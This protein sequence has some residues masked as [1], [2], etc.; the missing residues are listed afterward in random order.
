MTIEE[1]ADVLGVE[2]KIHYSPVNHKWMAK[3]ERAEIKG[4]GVLIGECGY[5]K[6]PRQALAQ[7]AEKIQGKTVV[8]DAYTNDR[9]ESSIP[10][11]LSCTQ[12]QG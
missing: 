1:L 3:L 10:A 7:Y 9:R 2:I 11:T 12:D 5:G 6:T 4:N 8:F